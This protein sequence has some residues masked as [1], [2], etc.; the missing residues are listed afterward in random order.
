MSLGGV[1]RDQLF[2]LKCRQV[3]LVERVEVSDVEAGTTRTSKKVSILVVTGDGHGT[4]IIREGAAQLLWLLPCLRRN[5]KRL[6]HRGLDLRWGAKTSPDV[7]PLPKST[8]TW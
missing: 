2:A 4:Q 3:E 1:S 7:Q 5:V 8:A 6:H